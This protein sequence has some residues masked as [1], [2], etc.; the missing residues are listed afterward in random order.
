MNSQA[1]KRS[2]QQCGIEGL[3]E[4]IIYRNEETGYT[5]GKLKVKGYNDF[6]AFTGN[7]LSVNPG[8]ILKLAGRWVNHPKFGVQFKVDSYVSVIPATARGIE[9]YLSSHL[10]KGIGPVMAKKIVTQFGTKTLDVIE[11]SLEMLLGVEGI[12]RKRLKMIE[13]AWVEQKGI[14]EVML[15]LQSHGVSAAYAI[16]IF[17]HY[18]QDSIQMVKENPY[19]L[20]TDIFGIGFITADKIA[21]DMGVPNDSQMRVE[22]GIL[23]VL[24]QLSGEGHVYY[25]YELLIEECEKMLNTERKIIGRAFGAIAFDERIVIEDINQAGEIKVN[26]KAVYLSK[27]YITEVGIAC[28]VRKFLTSENRLCQLDSD[29]VLDWV[30]KR[31]NIALAVNQ[32]VAIKKSMSEKMLIITGGPGTGKTTIINSITKIYQKLGQKILLAAPT[33]RAAKRMSGVTGCEAQTMHRLLGFTPGGSGFQK[34][35]RNPLEAGLVVIDEASMVDTILMYHFMKAVP[36]ESTV[37]LVGDVSQLPSVGAGNILKDMID[38]DVVSTVNLT[39]IFRQSRQS[40]I[41]VNAH[42]INRGEM[43]ILVSNRDRVRDF[44]FIEIEEPERIVEKITFLCKERIPQRFKFDSVKDI[45]VLTPMNK[46]ILGTHNLNTQLQEVLNQSSDELRING[47][48]FKKRD[49]VMQIVNNYEK[50]VFNGDIGII[51]TIDR[52]DHEVMIDFEGKLVIY[53]Y[54]DLDEIALAYAV[55]VHKAQ[56]S[57]YPVVVMPIHSQH[58]ILLQR[59]LLYTGIT[60]GQK[61]VVLLG[62]KKAMSVAINNNSPQRRYTYL[63]TRLKLLL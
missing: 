38:S 9:K 41:I 33:G 13:R 54:K 45:Q 58:Y 28:N 3:L 22:A 10:I 43:P 44:Y 6:V 23:Y 46:G 37:I 4:R 47:K 52:E 29:K 53:D 40:E 1:D 60:R 5:I 20:A 18:G 34:N 32:K 30:Q 42:S 25:P 11:N 49:K 27:F 39:E 48:V 57:E 7:L 59:N 63:K 2:Q 36:H 61:L 62:T 21:K 12:G 24:H 14:K 16:K 31:L 51:V 55:S 56:G 50:D 8:E 35:E 17:R 26:N 15:F 19:N